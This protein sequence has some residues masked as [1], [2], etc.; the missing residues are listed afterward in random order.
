[1]LDTAVNE[2]WV[3]TYHAPFGTV[4]SRRL[5]IQ[6][7]GDVVGA[8]AAFGMGAMN[9]TTTTHVV[10][11]G[12]WNLPNNDVVFTTPPLTGGGLGSVAG[13]VVT[14]ALQTSLTRA[15]ALSSSYDHFFAGNPVVLANPRYYAPPGAVGFPAMSGLADTWANFR[16]NVSDHRAVYINVQ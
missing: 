9:A 8:F 14:H 10:I 16:N 7:M 5:E 1:M 2:T 15:G 6:E 11:G 12:D 13:L 3:L 4:G